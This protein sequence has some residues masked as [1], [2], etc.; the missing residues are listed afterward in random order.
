MGDKSRSAVNGPNVILAAG[1]LAF[2]AVIY[3]VVFHGSSDGEEPVSVTS[4]TG[5]PAPVETELATVNEQS[6]KAAEVKVA[7]P[8]VEEQAET[9]VEDAPVQNRDVSQQA[10]GVNDVAESSIAP[11][12]SAPEPVEQEAV[13][14]QD[15]ADTEQDAPKT[16]VAEPKP[17]S[18]IVSP[19]FDVVRIDP[20]GSAVIAGSGEPGAEIRLMVNGAEIA[21]AT[22]DRNGQF[23]AL[24]DLP[25]SEDPRSLTAETDGAAGKSIT[26][27]G[28]VL[29]APTRPVE[30][31]DAEPIKPTEEDSAAA[32][33]DTEATAP[34]EPNVQVAA[35]DD[36]LP[37]TD[38]P[39]ENGASV[40][41]VVTDAEATASEQI[42]SSV[43]PQRTQTTDLQSANVEAQP[44]P[45][46]P[47][48]PDS[49]T[50]V[51][52]DASGVKVLQPAPQPA[53]PS[54]E[55]PS[56]VANLVIDTIT[57][58]PQGEVALAGRGAGASFARVYLNDRVVQTV[59][60]NP[61]GTWRT[62]LPDVDAGVYR[63]RIDEVSAQGDV[64]SRVETP[65]QREEPEVAAVSVQR[66]NAVIVQEGFTLWAIAKDRFGEGREYV[67]VY[68]ANRDL[69]RDP[70]L[71]YP[72]QVF[73]IPEG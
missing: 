67:R 22:A 70:D 33:N 52:A 11:S 17:E 20:Q 65:F 30:L 24:F 66:P 44:Q 28:A 9:V 1:I 25:P 64:T 14:L 40:E 31:V 4:E 45:E 50:V 39:V 59:K 35:Q 6:E 55:G 51:L 49:P 60:I 2:L 36:A 23:V 57:Y 19:S 12:D 58:D 72:G 3:G 34:A 68:E 15:K 71:I 10:E 42:A 18:A 43:E 32:A 56:V 62:P 16:T 8:S 48:V 46:V 26:S 47:D 38:A 37:E 13:A 5:T 61:D 29:I 73:E 53:V 69:I 27:T 54:D 41:E 21:T 63:L 7:K